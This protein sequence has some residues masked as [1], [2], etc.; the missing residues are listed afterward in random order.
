MLTSLQ[1][2]YDFHPGASE[3]EIEAFLEQVRTDD[4]YAG[5]PE[6]IA[7]RD[8]AVRDFATGKCPS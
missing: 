4:D 1:W 5:Q 2:V 8:Q 7:A 3:T 6:K